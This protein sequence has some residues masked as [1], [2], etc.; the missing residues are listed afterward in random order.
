MSYSKILVDTLHSLAAVDFGPASPSYHHLQLEPQSTHKISRQLHRILKANP[1]FIVLDALV[2]NHCNI[3]LLQYLQ[4]NVT[5]AAIPIQDGRRLV[6]TW[7]SYKSSNPL[8]SH[9]SFL[10]SLYFLHTYNS[11]LAILA[12]IP[13]LRHQNVQD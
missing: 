3:I 4:L 13:G 9:E 7:S 8:S 12:I 10:S 1:C 2:A 11:S 5:S 6:T